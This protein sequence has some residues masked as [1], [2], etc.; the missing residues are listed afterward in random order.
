MGPVPDEIASPNSEGKE[1][2]G[3]VLKTGYVTR[4]GGLVRDI[5]YPK[6][7]KLKLYNDAMKFVGILSIIAIIGWASCIPD[8]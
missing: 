7:I 3:L 6:E 5:L 8:F 1:F 2:Q 4:K